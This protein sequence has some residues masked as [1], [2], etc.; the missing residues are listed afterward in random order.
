M[1]V[2]QGF[3]SDPDYVESQS[4]NQP[5][6]SSC[7]CN[8]KSEHGVVRNHPF[9]STSLSNDKGEGCSSLKDYSIG[10]SGIRIGNIRFKEEHDNAMA[11]KVWV[12]T[13]ENLG[14]TRVDHDEVYS[15]KI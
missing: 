8:E 1:E 6:S 3:S 4:H 15:A 11:E 10:D 7:S 12:F 13:K 5:L 9:P 2:G 14:V